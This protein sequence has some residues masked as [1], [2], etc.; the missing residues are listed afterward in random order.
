[1]AAFGRYAEDSACL[2]VRLSVSLRWRV[3][4]SERASKHGREMIEESTYAPPSFPRPTFQI[5]DGEGS[6]EGV[7]EWGVA[8]LFAGSLPQNA[9]RVCFWGEEFGPPSFVGGRAA[10]KWLPHSPST[11]SRAFHVP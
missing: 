5:C 8:S 10:T 3:S 2:C 9:C 4:E 1:M 7:T 11:R 6:G